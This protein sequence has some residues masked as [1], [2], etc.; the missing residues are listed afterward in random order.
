MKIKETASNNN[1]TIIGSKQL[2]CIGTGL[3]T[4]A[5]LVRLLK[6]I[7]TMFFAVKFIIF[8][9]VYHFTATTVPRKC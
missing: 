3:G 5:E 8:Q 7:R 4:N 9:Y 1:G 6:V 2:A